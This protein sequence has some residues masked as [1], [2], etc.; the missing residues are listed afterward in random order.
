MKQLM[1]FIEDEF[2]QQ[3]KEVEGDW[4]R[5]IEGAVVPLCGTLERMQ[6]SLEGGVTIQEVENVVS[7]QSDGIVMLEAEMVILGNVCKTL[8]GKVEGQENRARRQNVRIVG[9]PEGVTGSSAMGMQAGF[10]DEEV[11]SPPLKETASKLP[12]IGI[13]KAKYHRFWKSEF[14]MKTAGKT[15]QVR[16]T[17]PERQTRVNV[18]CESREDGE[19]CQR[20]DDSGSPFGA[21]SLFPALFPTLQLE[22]R[23]RP[24][25][26]GLGGA[27]G[28]GSADGPGAF[29]RLFRLPQASRGS[30]PHGALPARLLY[31]KGRRALRRIQELTEPSEAPEPSASWLLREGS[32]GERCSRLR[33]LL[34][35]EGPLEP[36]AASFAAATP[37]QETGLQRTP[38]AGTASPTPAESEREEGEPRLSVLALAML[39]S[40]M[41][42]VLSPSPLPGPQGERFAGGSGS[43]LDQAS[44]TPGESGPST[45]VGTGERRKVT[46]TASSRVTFTLGLDAHGPAWPTRAEELRARPPTFKRRTSCLKKAIRTPSP[47]SGSSDVMTD[48]QDGSLSDIMTDS[49]DGSLSD[50]M[51]DSQDGSLSDIMTDSQDG[52]LSDIMADTQDARFSDLMADTQDGRLSDIMADTQDGRLSD[53]MADTQD[54]GLS[55]LMADTQDGGL[56][57]IMADTQDGSLSDTM[58]DTQDGR[59]SEI[60]ADSRDGSL[61]DIMAEI[62]DGCLND[63]VPYTQDGGALSDIMADNQDG[64][65]SDVMA[66]NQEGGSSGIISD[67][68]DGDMIDVMSDTKDGGLSDVMA[69]NQDGGSHG[70]IADT[71]DGGMIDARTDTKDGDLG[72]VMVDIQDGS[73]NDVMVDIQDGGSDDMAAATQDGGFSGQLAYTQDGSCSD[74]LADSHDGSSIDLLVDTQDDGSSDLLAES[75][76]GGSCHAL[77]AS[78]PCLSEDFSHGS[79]YTPGEGPSDFEGDTDTEAQIARLGEVGEEGPV[80]DDVLL[81]PELLSAVKAVSDRPD[82]GFKLVVAHSSVEEGE[83]SG[84]LCTGG[85]SKG[86][87]WGR[88]DDIQDVYTE[89]DQDMFSKAFLFNKFMRQGRFQRKRGNEHANE[90]P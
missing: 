15:Q 83:A 2:R 35:D 64:G 86:K 45:A 25:A 84:S 73:S 1:S 81:G 62:Q 28:A 71:Q 32:P 87:A 60:M 30:P 50:I 67:T 21:F 31:D 40:G 37:P 23:L 19:E 14:K 88:A 76:D 43:P 69:D 66:V 26:L 72:D 46:K 65:L 61:R 18:W 42:T 57:D 82:E 16:T 63:I 53:I 5:A 29:E 9:R 4:P 79:F 39:S 54:G 13:T 17:F 47:A 38:P 22:R 3:R 78:S 49:Q 12:T 55:D 58:A 80:S 41:P 20:V 48:S 10:V 68:K 51:T 85:H 89:I 27:A 70:I 8:R 74:L 24:A 6:K 75:Q 90:R 11:P 77:C 36:C 33:N 59:L 56:S 52:S 7:D 34:L 44:E